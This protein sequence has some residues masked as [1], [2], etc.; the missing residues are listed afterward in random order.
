MRPISDFFSH[1]SQKIPLSASVIKKNSNFT[2]IFDRG[3]HAAIFKAFFHT[4]GAVLGGFS[5]FAGAVL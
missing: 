4:Y 3:I 1:H 5:T 2:L